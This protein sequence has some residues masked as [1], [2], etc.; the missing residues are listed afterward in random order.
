MKMKTVSNATAVNRKV[1]D[2]TAEYE[3]RKLPPTHPL[4]DAWMFTARWQADVSAWNEEM[5]EFA[6]KC[7]AQQKQFYYNTYEN[8]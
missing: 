2:A 6:R 8:E 4:Y 7:V 5:I 1:I 3:D